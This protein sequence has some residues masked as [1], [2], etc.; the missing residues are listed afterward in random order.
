MADITPRI[1][2]SAQVIQS[3]SEKGFRV[4]GI[5]YDGPVMVFPFGVCVVPVAEVSGLSVETLPFLEKMT[6]EYV[7]LGGGKS[8]KMPPSDFRDGMKAL[9]A[10]VEPMSTGAAC[11]T[12][13]VLLA[14]GRS[15]AALLFPA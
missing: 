12:Y 7:V 10:V 8:V 6:V 5:D 11:R 13:N 9:G 14:E 1:D 4:S 15:V 3:Y 2:A